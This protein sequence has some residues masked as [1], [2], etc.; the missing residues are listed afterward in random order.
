[1]KNESG[2]DEIRSYRDEDV[3]H[4]M[5]ELIGSRRQV[6]MIRRFMFRGKHL[7]PGLILARFF[8]SWLKKQARVIHSVYDFQFRVTNRGVRK[9]ID[10]STRGAE[11]SGLGHL[12]EGVGYFFISNH[13]DIIM[14]TA[15]LS[16][17]MIENGLETPH[18][19]FGDNL[20]VNKFTENLMR[21]NKGFIVR[22]NLPMREQFV[23]SKQLSSYINHLLDNNES[24]WIAQRDGRS[25]DGSDRTKATVLK[26]LNFSKRKKGVSFHKM[27]SSY[28]IVPISV[29]YEID[30]CDAMKAKELYMKEQ[31]EGYEKKPYEDLKSV[32][33]GIK[34]WKGA[35]H[36]AI[37]DVL[38]IKEGD[39]EHDIA[40]GIDLEIHKNYKLWPTHYAA[41]DRLNSSDRFREHYSEEGIRLL[42]SRLDGLPEEM[43]RYLLLQYA[44]PVQ[45][46]IDEGVIK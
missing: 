19:A 43:H 30:P 4:I 46:Q 37:G 35:V 36:L 42:E 33:T 27:M 2:F 18:S 7:L 11:V 32:I 38:T 10:K 6:R 44:N 20:I 5:K 13:R 1:M 29:S 22:R 45:N 21:I 9:V 34:G 39:D 17:F 40:L 26:M 15:L 41:W 23:S 25:K 24:V 28:N 8:R 16:H 31:H 12:R 3:P 14:D